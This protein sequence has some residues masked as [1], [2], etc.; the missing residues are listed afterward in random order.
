MPIRRLPP[1]T[2]N[3]IAAG[4]VVE[5][6]ASAIKELVEN[7]LDAGST[8]IEVEADGGGLTRILVTDDGCGLSADELALAVERHATSKLAPQEDGSWDLLNIS[9]MG[10]RGEA[11]PSIGS[12]ARLSISSRPR[13]GGDAHAIL[14]EGGAMG[15]VGPAAFAGQHGARIEVRD[16]FYATPARLKFMKSP[17]AEQMAIAEEL[18]RQAMAHEA[19][20]FTLDLDGR[21]T[22][23]LSAEH[24]GPEGRLARL[25]AVLG[26]EFQ[27]NALQIDQ[28]RDGVRLTGF[29]GLPTYSRGNA[30][31]QYLFV[32][33]RPVRDRL[34]QGALRAAYADYLA[35][36]R[37]PTAAL[38]VELDP[39]YVDV[40]V[41]PAKAEVRFR[42]P[43]LV[44]GLI[45]GALRHALHAAGHRASTTVASAALAGFRP[46]GGGSPSF[47]GGYQPGPSAAGFSAWQA[48][49]WQPSPSY[50]PA[51]PMTLPGLN[52]ATARVES[53]QDW[54]APAFD[55]GAS[56][57]T[58][59]AV[60]D[61]V[62]FPLGAARAQVHE[63][64]VVAQTRD[65]I[66]I[67]D[68]HAAH[69]RLV[70]ER[71][72]REMDE[73]GVVRQTLLLP[74][75]VELDP[76]EAE[77]VLAKADELSALG[78]VIEPFGPGAVL[79]R[80]T[81][82]LLG[83]A[84]AAGLVRDIADDLSEN[85]QA[86]AL[87]ERLEEVCSTMACHGSVRAGRRL[88]AAEM[89]ALLREMEA[90]PHS[91]QCNHGR[92]TYVELKLADIE[93]LF[94]RR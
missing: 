88:N 24:P 44:R 20:A 7:S 40:N 94:G 28:E 25:A 67:V 4:E 45:V 84:D 12:V 50:R 52:E 82:A 21:R 16:L 89:N 85:G 10:F 27:D 1:E 30:A 61:P 18:K 71:M 64:Y 69:E 11:L 35:R 78:L 79:V 91:G 62:D 13:A 33:G 42:D 46:E 34:L 38:Y 54:G 2:V 3:R 31:H 87:K 65:G 19:V 70:Y 49:G 39:T 74:E 37:H 73:G 47:G 22:L 41:H 55:Q 80:E 56:Q 26:R 86:L 76:A 60:F 63:T 23:R 66:V 72:K 92:P 68:Q 59:G 14:V 43:S 8:R 90:T 93:R 75:V 77:R 9:T 36:D 51:A 29:A 83:E 17:R 53:I 15:G 81:P 5:R 48:G 57:P 6:P 58:A 32:N